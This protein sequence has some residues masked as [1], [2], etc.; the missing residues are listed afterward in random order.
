MC[1]FHTKDPVVPDKYMSIAFDC[2][3]KIQGSALSW[4]QRVNYALP[5]LP[6]YFLAGPITVLQGIYAKHF[7]LALTTIA[8]VIFVVRLFDA[9]TDPL[10]GYYSDRY[11]TCLGNRKPFFVGGSVLFVLSSWFLYVPLGFDP[12]QDYVSVSSGYFFGWF[13][14]FYLAFTLF[15]IPHL[16]WGGEL[17][18]NARE[19]NSIY[20]VRSFFVFFGSFLFFLVPLMPWFESSEI[21]PQTLKVSVLVA[22]A[23]M[24]PLLYLSLRYVPNLKNSQRNDSYD[25]RF[26]KKE[27]IRKVVRSVFAN[28]PLL[29]LT[30]AHSLSGFG[31][32]MYLTLL[33]IFVD[34]YLELGAQF[35]WVYVV[36]FGLSILSLRLWYLLANYCGKQGTWITGMIFIAIGM[37]GSGMLSPSHTGQLELLFCLTLILSGFAAFNVMVP[38]LLSDVVDYGTWKFGADRAATY[39]SL[40]TFVNK[41]MGALGGALGLAIAGWVGFDPAATLHSDIAI[42]GLRVGISWVPVV[43]IVFSVFFISRIPITARRHAIIQ[44]Q[45]DAQLARASRTMDVI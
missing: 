34:A 20:A 29:T 19:K 10:I 14:V 27:D 32:G 22:G 6:L 45:L 39:F 43:C 25:C 23:W 21:T 40:Y 41:S 36:S 35:A 26:N 28:K 44:R 13:L 16:A 3:S 11:F 1:S 33:F 38:S 15:E 31:S 7:G 4:S 2:S 8:T 37:V 24:M 30:L 9:I 5:L 17:A 12:Q 18:T 42:D